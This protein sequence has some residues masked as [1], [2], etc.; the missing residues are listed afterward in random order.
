MR[1]GFASVAVAAC[2]MWIVSDDL[3]A[4]GSNDIRKSLRLREGR[5]LVSDDCSIRRFSLSTGAL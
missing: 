4:N 1:C 3:C 2:L 5:P